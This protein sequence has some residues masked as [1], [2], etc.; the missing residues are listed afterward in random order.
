MGILGTNGSS[1]K[2][3]C[4]GED[5]KWTLGFSSVQV[6]GNPDQGSFPER[7]AGLTAMGKES[8]GEE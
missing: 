2:P 3:F 8:E 1:I 4:G 6:A 7:G 5:G